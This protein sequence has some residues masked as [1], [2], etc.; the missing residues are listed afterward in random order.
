MSQVL[1]ESPL[2]AGRDAVARHAWREAFDLLSVA[3]STQPLDPEDL[4]K[5]AEAAWWTGR[6]QHCIESRERAFAGYQLSLIHI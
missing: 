6:L 4:E 5:L 2:Q 3:D 1:E